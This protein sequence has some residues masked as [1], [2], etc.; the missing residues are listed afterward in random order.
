MTANL[1]DVNAEALT[2]DQQSFNKVL[3]AASPNPHDYP[4]TLESFLKCLSEA[5]PGASTADVLSRMP[6]G[7]NRPDVESD[8]KTLDAADLVKAEA[9]ARVAQLDDPTDGLGRVLLDADADIGS[10]LH[11]P[12]VAENRYRAARP[13]D[14]RYQHPQSGRAAFDLDEKTFLDAGLDLVKTLRRP[15]KVEQAE[16]LPRYLERQIDSAWRAGRSPQ[17]RRILLDTIAADHRRVVKMLDRAESRSPT[18]T[19]RA[20]SSSE[21]ETKLRL[22]SSLPPDRYALALDALLWEE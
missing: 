14:E 3:L 15:A 20:A 18:R 1:L 10:M 9:G 2:R 8:I 16:Q 6:G 7:F 5:G 13:Y 4:A 12:V 22:L 17:E 11:D 19:P 21:F